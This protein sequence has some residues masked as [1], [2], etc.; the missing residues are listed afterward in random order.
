[1][2]E[3]L[4]HL[5]DFFLGCT[6]QRLTW[7]RSRKDRNGRPVYPPESYVV[8]LSCGS[9]FAYDWDKM[10]VIRSLRRSSASVQP[11]SDPFSPL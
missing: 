3:L 6:H 4:L 10:K 5:L 1:M 8:C 9:E 7:P 11:A 2:K